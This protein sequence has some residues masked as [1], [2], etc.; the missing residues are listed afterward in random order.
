MSEEEMARRAAVALW[1]LLDDIDT[2]DDACRDNDAEFRRL[3]R[4]TQRLRF[5]KLSGEQFDQWRA[6]LAKAVTP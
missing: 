5:A 4:E 2:L 3:A 6:E 1:M